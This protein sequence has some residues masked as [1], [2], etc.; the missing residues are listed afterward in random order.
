M[1]VL[2]DS[3]GGQQLVKMTKT[4]A[5]R[6]KKLIEAAQDE[7]TGDFEFPDEVNEILDEC[8]FISVPTLNTMGDGWGWYEEDG[9]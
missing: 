6:I 7:D 8:E 5:N 2:I 3:E 9:E 1:Y 4:Q